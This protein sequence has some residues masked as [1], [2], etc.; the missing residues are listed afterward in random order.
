LKILDRAQPKEVSVFHSV[1]EPIGACG[2]QIRVDSRPHEDHEG[3]KL[4]SAEECE[5]I[6]RNSGTYSILQEV[7]QRLCPYH[8]V[9]AK[10]VE[11]GCLVLLE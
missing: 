8:C 6:A 3:S 7:Y 1:W 9:N 2:L 5:T 11:E 4:G 10:I